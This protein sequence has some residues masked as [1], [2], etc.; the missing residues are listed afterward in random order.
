MSNFFSI[1]ILLIGGTLIVLALIAPFA[2]QKQGSFRR[3]LQ[4]L[5]SFLIVI[6]GIGFFGLGLSS[7]GGLNRLP[8]SF[9]WPVFFADGVITTGDG[10]FVVPHNPSGR[11]QIYDSQWNFI[12]GWYVTA[13]TFKLMAFRD[14]RFAVIASRSEMRF[15]FNTDGKL[16]S[17]TSYTPA[18]YDSFPVQG[19]AFFVPTR[20]WLIFLCSPFIAWVITFAGMSILVVMDQAA[21]RKIKKEKS[22]ALSQ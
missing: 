22:V 21:K 4:F 18:R 16:I 8:D 5:A 13:G 20:P 17:K 2:S 12:R 7:A 6:G 3:F 15:V 9:E 11:V 10:F 14:S 1:L 19:S